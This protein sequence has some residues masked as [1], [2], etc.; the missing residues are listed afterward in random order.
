MRTLLRP[1]RRSLLVKI[2]GRGGTRF[3]V[4]GPSA[5]KPRVVF[6]LEAAVRL[7]ENLEQQSGADADSTSSSPTRR[8][9]SWLAPHGFLHGR[10]APD[11]EYRTAAK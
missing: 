1:G 4:R 9:T 11:Q 10:R 5:G 2:E 3:V 7:F 6:D 8:Q